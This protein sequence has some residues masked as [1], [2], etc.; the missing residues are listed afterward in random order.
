MSGS[1]FA[2][3]TTSERVVN[4][5]KSLGLLLGC[6]AD[7]EEAWE[8]KACLKSK[9]FDQIYDAIEKMVGE[10][11]PYYGGIYLNKNAIITGIF[12]GAHS[13]GR[14]KLCEIR[15]SNGP[16]VLP[17][18]LSRTHPR[19]ASETNCARIHAL[20][21]PIFQLVCTCFAPTIF[22][23]NFAI[24][25]M[26]PKRNNSLSAYAIPWNEFDDY[27]QGRFEN[28]VRDVVATKAHFGPRADKVQAEIIGFYT[29]GKGTRLAKNSTYYLHKYTQVL[30]IKYIQYF[31]GKTKN[32]YG[33]CSR[34]SR[35]YNSLC[36]LFGR[37]E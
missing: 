17:T 32:L 14:H 3:W 18:W 13:T 26:I 16:R 33:K 23:P 31:L 19:V 6:E 12:L 29:G 1:V 7:H 5:T 10:Y 2:A 34:F 27:D 28:F 22:L 4:E 25:A 37:V 11:G 30:V 20:G 9:T 36:Q 8:L 21:V 24:L 35:I 15:P